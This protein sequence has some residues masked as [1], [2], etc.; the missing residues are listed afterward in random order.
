VNINGVRVGYS[1]QHKAVVAY[2]GVKPHAKVESMKNVTAEAFSAVCDFLREFG[3]LDL[4]DKL[5]GKSYRIM[6]KR[7]G[8]PAR[9]A[10]A[11]K[12]VWRKKFVKRK[13]KAA[14]QSGQNSGA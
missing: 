3:P 11:V 5:D 14:N 10:M 2:I 9:V 1:K 13:L 8:V 7:H 12:K 6:L 4:T